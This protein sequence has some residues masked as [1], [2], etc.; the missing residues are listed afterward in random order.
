[1]D[2]HLGRYHS[3]IA[4]GFRTRTLRPSARADIPVHHRD[5]GAFLLLRHALAAR[6]VY[7]EISAVVRSFRKRDRAFLAQAR[8]GKRVRPARRAAAVLADLGTL[9]RARLF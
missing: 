3:I 5:V 6:A 9:Y 4:T 7:D 8:A 2:R 1:M